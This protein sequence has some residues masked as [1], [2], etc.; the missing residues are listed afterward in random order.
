MTDIKK[1]LTFQSIEYLGYCQSQTA[2]VTEVAW[3]VTECSYDRMHLQL[4]HVISLDAHL[5]VHLQ[6]TTY[7]STTSTFLSL[8]ASTFVCI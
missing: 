4:H 1:G 8:S 7:S 6:H 5:P 3:T 2:V